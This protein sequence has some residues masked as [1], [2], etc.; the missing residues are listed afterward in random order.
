MGTSSGAYELNHERYISGSYIKTVQTHTI[1]QTKTVECMDQLI[2]MS[3]NNFTLVNHKLICEWYMIDISWY[4][5]G[6]AF[7]WPSS[8]I[9]GV[10]PAAKTRASSVAENVSQSS[11]TD[12]ADTSLILSLCAIWSRILGVYICY[13]DV[14]LDVHKTCLIST[15]NWNHV[16]L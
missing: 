8:S 12:I 7:W 16:K 6:V 2:L 9:V 10:E 1:T 4:L 14:Q 5:P 15:S 13:L 11:C 3:P